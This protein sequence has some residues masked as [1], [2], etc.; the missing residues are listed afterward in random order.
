MILVTDGQMRQTLAVIRSLGKKGIKVM[1]GDSERISMGF[2]SKYTY[3]HIIY[4][5]PVENEKAFVKF[6]LNTVKTEEIEMIIPIRDKCLIPLSKYK[7]E[8]EKYTKIPI[9]DY[10]LVMKARDKGETLRI[11]EKIGIPTPKTYYPN[12][13]DDLVKITEYPVIIKPRMSSGSRGC[14]FCSN[15]QQLRDNFDKIS[16]EYPEGLLIQEYIPKQKEI[17]YY[18]L[19]N[20]HSEL[21]AFT[22]QKRLRS[23]PTEG[24]PSTLRETIQYDQ[25]RELGTKLLKFMKWQGVAMV[26]FRI[27][28]RDSVP[29]LMEVN[30][31]FWGSLALSIAAGVDFP[32]L[33]YQLALNGD[34]EENLDYKIG[35][36]C[37]WLLPG[38]ILWFLSDKKSLANLKSFFTFTGMQYDI[39]DWHDLK[40]VLGVGLT[41]IV[42]LFNKSKRKYTFRR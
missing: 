26:E 16:K 35:I 24:G 40:P 3:K 39:F 27:D 9:P 11:A 41:S 30:P 14:V 32:Y 33:L 15:F 34:I 22:I 12:S 17:G 37:R 10:G 36:K 25:I 2:F 31:R 6:V 29:K 42:Y 4:P 5:D 13:I 28:N 8:F 1:V 23:Y 18:A 21:R 20:T 38:D 7:K 19:F